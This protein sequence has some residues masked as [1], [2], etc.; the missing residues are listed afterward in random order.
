MTFRG[1]G[2]RARDAIIMSIQTTLFGTV[3]REPR[4][5]T[6]YEHPET[7]Y[8]EFV[9]RYYERNCQRGKSKEEVVRDAQVR[10]DIKARA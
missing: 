6:I 3:A 9:E 4:R 5:N 1:E 10:V 8:E 2:G 7:R